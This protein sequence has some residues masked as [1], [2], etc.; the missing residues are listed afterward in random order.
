MV[1][2]QTSP[3]RRRMTSETASVN[4]EQHGGGWVV[5]GGFITASSLSQRGE[6]QGMLYVCVNIGE[7]VNTFIKKTRKK[8]GIF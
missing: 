7:A 4:P 2:P 1:T 5:V 3:H 8:S 6:V